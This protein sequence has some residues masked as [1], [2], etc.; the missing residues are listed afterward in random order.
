MINNNVNVCLIGTGRAGMIHAK[1]LNTRVPNANLIAICDTSQ[2][3]LEKAKENLSVKY[4]YNNYEEALDNEEIDAVVIVTPTKLHKDIVIKAAKKKKHILCEKPLA[5]TVEDCD[6]MIKVVNQ[7]NVKL[8]VGF[9]RRFDESF[10][11]AKKVIDSGELGEIVLVKSLTRGPSKPQPWMYDINISGGPIAEVNSHDLD[12]V[13]WFSDS[14]V[15][16]IYS[17]GGNFR[18]R[19]IAEKYPDFYDTVSMNIELE[20]GM[21]AAID[22][23]QYVQ[24]GYDARVE[25][26]GTHGN[27]ML[28]DTKRNNITQFSKNGIIKNQFIESWRDL[29]S[30]A[31]LNEDIA[32]V[33]AVLNDTQPFVTG[34]DGRQAVKLVKMGIDSLLSG[35]PVFA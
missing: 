33:N 12:T 10:R 4:T 16:S 19:E 29:F 27:L 8:Q 18:L 3:S 17:I 28:G 2:E 26:L 9:M 32:F 20:D 1:N 13:R 22:G 6:E 23:A 25:I 35:K 21:I 7:N 34:K 14:E 11:E 24:Y 31:Y 30:N 15:K 5:R